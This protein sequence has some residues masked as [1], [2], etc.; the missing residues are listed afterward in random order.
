MSVSQPCPIG[1]RKHLSRLDE[2][3]KLDRLDRMDRMDTLDELDRLDTLDKK[4][5]IGHLK[6]IIKKSWT[7]MLLI[8]NYI[9]I[10]CPTN[11]TLCLRDKKLDTLLINN[12]PIF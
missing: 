5:R 12:C 6:M 11:W 10:F 2:L 4:S 3:D 9:N 7:D 1:Q 8:Y